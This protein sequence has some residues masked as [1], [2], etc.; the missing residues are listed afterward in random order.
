MARK[1]KEKEK[2]VTKSDGNRLTFGS[3]RNRNVRCVVMTRY[4]FD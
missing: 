4:V 1:E 3:C 2:E